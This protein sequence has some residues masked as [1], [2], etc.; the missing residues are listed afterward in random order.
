MS[1]YNDLQEED[2]KKL[3]N[4]GGHCG[5]ST[6][7]SNMREFVFS[8]KTQ[9]H[10][11]IDLKKTWMHLQLAARVIAGIENPKDVL[12]VSSYAQSHVSVN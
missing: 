4:S 7:N 3:L 11:L 8:R 5:E 6:L 10:Y 9:G 2:V 1:G 12:V